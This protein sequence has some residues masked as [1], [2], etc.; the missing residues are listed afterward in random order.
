M[1]MTPNQCTLHWIISRWK[2]ID[3]HRDT[4]TDLDGR[5]LI[6]QKWYEVNTDSNPCSLYQ[7][8]IMLRDMC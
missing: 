1:N 3:G 8:V 2:E 7:Y 5:K 6:Q 4:G